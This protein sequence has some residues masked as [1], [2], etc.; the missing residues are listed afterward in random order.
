MSHRARREPGRSRIEREASETQVADALAAAM[1]P[2]MALSAWL[3]GRMIMGAV[4]NDGP[5]EKELVLRFEDGNELVVRGA[6]TAEFVS[7]PVVGHSTKAGGETISE[8]ALDGVQ[9][10]PDEVIED[11]EWEEVE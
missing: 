2:G 1:M 8:V 11:A 7:K 5:L 9:A 10:L 3:P 4:V 6:F